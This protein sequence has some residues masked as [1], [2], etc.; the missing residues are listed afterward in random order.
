LLY[1]GINAFFMQLFKIWMH[2]LDM[3]ITY[4][5]KVQWAHLCTELNILGQRMVRA[6]EIWRHRGPPWKIAPCN[7][8]A[9]LLMVV[10]WLQVDHHLLHN[11]VL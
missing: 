5:T 9:A 7:L 8:S 4:S 2:M 10:K 6:A 1:F 11:S 3:L